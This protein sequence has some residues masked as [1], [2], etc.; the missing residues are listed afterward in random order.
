MNTQRTIEQQEAELKELLQRV[1]QAPLEPITNSV[2]KLDKHLGVLEDLEEQIKDVR[3]I[4]LA[5]LRQTADESYKCTRSINSL[6]ENIPAEVTNK[7]QP[8]LGQELGK[9]HKVHQ[10]SLED[11]QVHL[12]EHLDAAQ[13]RVFENE[14]KLQKLLEAQQEQILW[15]L[16][17]NEIV[18]IQ[19][20]NELI[21]V[22]A[23]IKLWLIA[24]V[25]LAFVGLI[26]MATLAT[27]LYS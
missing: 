9:L 24:N 2:Q 15:L 27:R 5:A 16:R 18:T 20:Q 23:G 21:Q 13:H 7:I 17:Q 4:D 11:V 26:G 25:S 19:F 3:D 14:I 6:I 12:K 8:L 22:H 1:M 10:S